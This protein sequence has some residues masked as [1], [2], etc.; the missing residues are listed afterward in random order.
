MFIYMTNLSFNHFENSYVL[1]HHQALCSSYKS[2][3]RKLVADKLLNKVYEIVKL[4]VM[5]MLNSCNHL[6]FFTNETINIR[7]KRVINLCCHVSSFN[8]ENFYLK[9]IIEVA[10]KMSAV[11][12]AEWVINDCKK[13][14]DNQLERINCIVTDICFIMKAMWIE[15][16]KYSEMKHV[17]FVSCDNHELQLLL[18]D[19][20]KFSFFAD[21]LQKAQLIV[22]NFRE[23]NKKLIILWKYQKKTY[24]QRRFLIL[25]VLI[26]WD[27]SVDLINSVLRSKETLLNYFQ[28]KH[29]SIDHEKTHTLSSFVD[30]Y[31]FWKQLVVARK[32]LDFIHRAQYMFETESHKLYTMTIN[33]NCQGR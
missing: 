28:Q 14:I 9:A 32:I 25:N 1:A 7:K 2:L 18:K 15:I 22:I 26:R 13:T 27:T 12:Q 5:Q 23:S 21:V 30:D 16:F 29:S 31:S 33:W 17:F 11:V 8:D 4:Q 10:K 6:S 20:M 19:V 3:S 24:N